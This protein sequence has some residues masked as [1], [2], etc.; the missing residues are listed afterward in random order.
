MAGEYPKGRKQKGNWKSRWKNDLIN[1]LILT[2]E[3]YDE[4]N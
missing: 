1:D 3:G 4:W 2:I